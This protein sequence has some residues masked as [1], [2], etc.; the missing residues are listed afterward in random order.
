LREIGIPFFLAQVLLEHGEWLTEQG[1]AED[2]R[3]LLDEARS[4]FDRLRAAPYLER[5]DKVAPDLVRA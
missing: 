2:A 1:R 3:P 5:V 4:T